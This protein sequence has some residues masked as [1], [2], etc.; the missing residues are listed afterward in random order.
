MVQIIRLKKGVEFSG[1]EIEILEAML[2]A[3]KVYYAHGYD[4]IVTSVLDGKHSKH[5][6]HYTGYALDLRTRHLSSSND[7]EVIARKIAALLGKDYDVVLE[8][9]HIHIEYDPKG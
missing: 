5:S 3:S 9:T 1:I 2:V 7:E 8:S 4:T 6:L